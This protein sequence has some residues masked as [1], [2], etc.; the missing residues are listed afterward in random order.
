MPAGISLE[1]KSAILALNS[2]SKSCRKIAKILLDKGTPVSKQTVNRVL[3]SVSLETI[4]IQKP[5][6][7]LA[8]QNLPSIRTASLIQKVKKAIFVANPPSLN[9]LAKTY[10]VAKSTIHKI[11]HQDIRAVKRCKTKTHSLSDAQVIQ[12]Y[13]RGPRFLKWIRGK[14]YK[15]ILTLD[16]AWMS[17]TNANGQRRI[18]YENEETTA[19]E[20][21][22][23]TFKSK[24]PKK[25][26][27]VGG[28]CV[29]GKTKLRYV[30][31]KSK[32][33]AAYF[34]KHILE[35]IVRED[36]PR[37]YPGEE[38]K[39]ILH[40]DSAPGHVAKKTYEWLKSN[41]IKFIPKEDW[42]SNAPDLS[43]MDYGLN[44]IFKNLVWKWKA[45]DVPA[46]KRAMTRVWNELDQNVI[47]KTLASWQKRVE[48]MIEKRAYKLK[49]VCS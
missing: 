41:Q 24:H 9:Q 15:Y 11:I 37:L 30:P 31:E 2:P 17:V 1:I 49:I 45:S 27:Y 29:N 46:L 13:E 44:G 19:P 47:V 4:G 42:P 43:P 14:K 22:T 21:W 16:E 35:P 39:V 33:N 10:S 48:L 18:Y 12:R 7:R 20:S 34:I 36:I 8:T 5:A 3:R 38:H 28:I 25:V 23:K 32:V 40:F 26:M 6:K